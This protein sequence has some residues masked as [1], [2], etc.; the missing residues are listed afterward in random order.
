M[1]LILI[2]TAYYIEHVPSSHPTWFFS[3][4]VRLYFLADAAD[5]SF[6]IT[7]NE[8]NIM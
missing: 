4:G 1:D 5:G 6:F 7:S 2:Y 8:A 3:K